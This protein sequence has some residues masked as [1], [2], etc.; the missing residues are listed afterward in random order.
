MRERLEGAGVES[1]LSSD[2][3]NV[4]TVDNI[5]GTIPNP[6]GSTN[7]MATSSRFVE[8]GSYLRLKNIQLGY[9]FNKNFIQ[10]I[11]LSKLRVYA[12]MSNVFTI[13]NYKGYDPEVGSTIDYGN[14]PQARTLLFGMN[15]AF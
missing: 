6:K 9:N 10:K 13:T 14:Y 2:M 1:V 12:Q 3:Y 8:S 11:G 7:N 15:L 4:W 5:E